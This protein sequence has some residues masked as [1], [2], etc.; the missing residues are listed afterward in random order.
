MKR[1]PFLVLIA[2]LFFWPQHNV[3]AQAKQHAILLSCVGGLGD[4]AFNWYRSTTTGTGYALIHG[5]GSSCA[6]TDT[7][8]T[9]GTKYF[10]VVTGVDVGGF[11]SAFS[12]EV[13]AVFPLGAAVPSAVTATP[14]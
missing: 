9:G 14:Q 5:G 12:Q 1:I 7:T 6:F 3:K 10:Y 13:A 4:M 8:G 11:E 2:S